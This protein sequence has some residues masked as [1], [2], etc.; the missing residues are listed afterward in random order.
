MTAAPPE[1]LD[2]NTNRSILDAVAERLQRDLRPDSLPA[3]SRIEHLLDALRRQELGNGQTSW[4]DHREAA[5]L[6]V[7]R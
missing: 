4:A 2:R 5:N 3:S 6:P 1:P 7:S